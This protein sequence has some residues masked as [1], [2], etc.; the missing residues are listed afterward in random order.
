[1]ISRYIIKKLIL[2]VPLL[3]GITFVSFSLLRA[4]P[5][6]IA[7]SLAGERASQETIES[8]RKEIG[9]DKGI[10]PQYAGYLKMLMRGDFG[11]SY[12]TNRDVLT[13]ITLKFP[14]TLKLA[15]AAMAIAVPLGIIMG[16][17]A[18]YRKR[19][20]AGQIIDSLSLAGLSIPV[21][22]SAILIMI[23][24]SLW[25]KLF[26]PSGTGNIRFLILPACTLSIPAAATLV[27][28][29][30]TSVAEVLGMPFITTA[31]AKGL[32]LR[33]I[34]IHHVLKNAIVTIIGL[35]FGSYLNG[36]VVTETIFGWDGIGRFT[37]EGIIKRDYPV[38]MGCI[39]AGTVAFVLVNL[40][41][42]V[43][44][45]YLD[46]RIRLH[47]GYDGEEK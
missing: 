28:V 13:D 17:A 39:I 41:I 16:Y 21:F 44:Y 7:L 22:W 30:R 6:D 8:I 38:I 9:A 34:H 40:F 1:V 25:L 32:P 12:Y 20:T 24:F 26:P 35:D 19:G 18:A 29:T 42:D 2:L 23:I 11:R 14:N 33:K 10:L 36:A 3:L 46:P 4:L 15:F 27:R 5:G 43:L 31:M 37:M 45:H 47:G